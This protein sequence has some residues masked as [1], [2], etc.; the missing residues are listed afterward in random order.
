MSCLCKGVGDGEKQEDEDNGPDGIGNGTDSKDQDDNPSRYAQSVANGGKIYIGAT[1]LEAT[2]H[3]KTELYGESG[4]YQHG[5]MGCSE[6]KHRTLS[7]TSKREDINETDGRSPAHL[8]TTSCM[9]DREQEA[10]VMGCSDNQQRRVMCTSSNLEHFDKTDGHCCSLIPGSD[11]ETGDTGCGEGQE[12]KCVITSNHQNEFDKTGGQF[13]PH[14]KTSHVTDSDQRPDVSGCKEDQCRSMGTISKQ[15]DFDKT[16]GQSMSRTRTTSH[17]T[18]SDQGPNV[19]GCNEDQHRSTD[20]CTFSNQEDFHKTDGHSTADNR[21]I[22]HVPDSDQENGTI[23]Y[24]EDKQGRSMR[25]FSKQEEFNK[26]ESLDS[27][28]VDHMAA[29]HK[30]YDTIWHNNDHE[31]RSQRTSSRQEDLVETDGQLTAHTMTTRRRESFYNESV[32]EDTALR[33]TGKLLGIASSNK[34]NSDKSTQGEVSK[35]LTFSGLKLENLADSFKEHCDEHAKD[36]VPENTTSC[37]FVSSPQH[38]CGQIIKFPTNKAHTVSTGEIDREQEEAVESDLIMNYK[39]VKTTQLDSEE[40]QISNPD[41]PSV[42]KQGA[43]KGVELLTKESEKGSCS[44]ENGELKADHPDSGGDTEVKQMGISSVLSDSFSC[45]AM[46]CQLA[47]GTVCEKYIQEGKVGERE[48]FKPSISKPKLPEMML[49]KSTRSQEDDGEDMSEKDAAVAC[50][51]VTK[52][53]DC[54]VGSVGRAT[55]AFSGVQSQK[56]YLEQGARPKQTRTSLTVKTHDATADIESNNQTYLEQGARPKQYHQLAAGQMSGEPN[57]RNESFLA[58]SPENHGLD[59]A[60]LA[61]HSQDCSISLHSYQASD[62]FYLSTPPLEWNQNGTVCASNKQADRDQHLARS[63]RL[64]RT[65][66]TP[67]D[68]PRYLWELPNPGSISGFTAQTEQITDP[69]QQS[70]CLPDY[71]SATPSQAVAFLMQPDET[72]DTSNASLSYIGEVS[73]RHTSP[74]CQS[75]IDNLITSSASGTH[76]VNCYAAVGNSYVH[77]QQSSLERPSNTDGD[78]SAV[79]KN[80][81]KKGIKSISCEETDTTTEDCLFEDEVESGELANVNVSGTE[82]LQ[83]VEETLNTLESRVAEACAMVERVFRERRAR[84]Q[85]ARER[86]ERAR[87]E[88]ERVFREQEEREREEEERAARAGQDGHTT[89]GTD[90][91]EPGIDGER[92]PVQE[93]P[94]WLCE[95]YQRR[96][97]V[98]FP[99]CRGYHPCHR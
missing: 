7:T 66:C 14:R 86:E 59:V 82:S 2:E 41:N 77:P 24:I 53:T 8:R 34:S 46:R 10:D 50:I 21:I 57:A 85:E 4:S 30:E 97:K 56:S 5:T 70:K 89:A 49:D 25:R 94:Q 60:F 33:T 64:I 87:E 52:Q 28:I 74:G 88:R 80:G 62:D 83:S 55:A 54:G 36:R 78:E 93:S 48:D 22:S 26:P 91:Q 20:T 13:T 98:R 76:Q 68:I 79:E 61:R 16:G 40:M 38:T 95:H 84:E 42:L 92:Y 1:G 32:G 47:E 31:R 67:P 27:R 15:E 96:C 44:P 37:Q 29:I 99:C 63:S 43:V 75:Q 19:I 39:M 11:Q 3:L 69:M 35:R 18:D 6:K 45:N 51:A 65:D 71:Q 58:S 23:G 72:P 73:S 17:I 9:C 81:E 12:R 90:N